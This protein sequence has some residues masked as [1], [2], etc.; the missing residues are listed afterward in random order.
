MEI[1]KKLENFVVK[2]NL[3]LKSLSINV[4]DESNELINRAS[5]DLGKLELLVDEVYSKMHLFK[6]MGVKVEAKKSIV[7]LAQLIHV[8]PRG[9][10]IFFYSFTFSFNYC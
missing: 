6:F 8:R 7:V 9:L 3:D 4:C 2:V 1:A 10:A 5:I